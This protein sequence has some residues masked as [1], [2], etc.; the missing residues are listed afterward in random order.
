VY[1]QLLGFGA[2]ALLSFTVIFRL[3]RPCTQLHVFLSHEIMSLLIIRPRAH[4]Q[5]TRCEDF[6]LR[7]YQIQ[8][9]IET[10]N[11]LEITTARKVVR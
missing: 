3:G 6:D 7:L 5:G 10:G 8:N 9:T 2:D 1:V 11:S 4:L